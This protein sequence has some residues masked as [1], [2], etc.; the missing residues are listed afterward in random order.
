MKGTIYKIPL[1]VVCAHTYAHQKMA[2]EYMIWY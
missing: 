2:E 1:N